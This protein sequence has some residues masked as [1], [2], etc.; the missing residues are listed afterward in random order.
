MKRLAA[1]LLP[2]LLL[3]TGCGEAAVSSPSPPA[4]PTPVSTPSPTPSPTV[5]PPPADDTL[6][7]VSDYIPGI[8]VDLKYASTD[9]FTGKAIY[10]FT[11]ARLRY[12]TVKKLLAAQEKLT[13][14]GYALE[15]WDAYR[16]ASAQQALWNARPDPVYVADPATGGSNH[17]RGNT[18]DV[19][20]VTADGGAVEMPS[21]FDDASPAADRDYSDVSAAARQDARLLESMMTECGFAGYSGEWWHYADTDVYP[22]IADGTS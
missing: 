16:P 11:E 13:A 5:S 20:L 18:V 15:I 9:N 17:T 14:E 2:I 3:L 7:A 4:A 21:A 12:G 10:D 6:V 8:V 19:T 22:M 1:L